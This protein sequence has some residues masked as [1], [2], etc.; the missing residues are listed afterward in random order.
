M[1]V[2]KRLLIQEPRGTF[3]HVQTRQIVDSN[4]AFIQSQWLRLPNSATMQSR[5]TFC[6]VSKLTTECTKFIAT[7]KC[8]FK[9]SWSSKDQQNLIIWNCQTYHFSEII[10][11]QWPLS[12]VRL[13]VAMIWIGGGVHFFPSQLSD[14]AGHTQACMHA[15]IW[16]FYL[17]KLFI[18]KMCRH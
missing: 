3:V 16:K 11:P 9:S 13:A 7:F 17:V 1:A 2:S 5:E 14:V 10:F 6:M 8:Y 15:N 4:A 12:S 18:I